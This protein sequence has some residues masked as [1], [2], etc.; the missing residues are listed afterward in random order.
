MRCKT[1]AGRTATSWLD[2][3]LGGNQG[4]RLI[5]TGRRNASGGLATSDFF[6]SFR[7]KGNL[8]VAVMLSLGAC[9]KPK[10]N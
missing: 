10:L 7:L 1:F 6:L 3:T 5:L 8:I 9:K 2:L 4:C